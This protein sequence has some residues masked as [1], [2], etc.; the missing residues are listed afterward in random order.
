M[1]IVAVGLNLP[2]NFSRGVN[3]GSKNQHVAARQAMR[4]PALV[5][6]VE[7]HPHAVFEL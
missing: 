7:Q 6:I 5:Q 4:R 1:K 2:L 3:E